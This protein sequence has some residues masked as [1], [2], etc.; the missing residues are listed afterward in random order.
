[1]ANFLITNEGYGINLALLER[2]EKSEKDVILTVAG[3]PYTTRPDEYMTIEQ[4]GNLLSKAL[5][6]PNPVVFWGK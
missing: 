1:M 3:Q 2:F 5:R 4:V 6:A